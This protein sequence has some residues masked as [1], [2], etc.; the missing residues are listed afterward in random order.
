MGMQK[1]PLISRKA[2]EKMDNTASTHDYTKKILGKKRYFKQI[3]REEF[4][5]LF[6]DSPIELYDLT[7]VY[8]LE[9]FEYF[10][11]IRFTNTKERQVKRL[12]M[13][14]FLYLDSPLPYKKIN[15]TLELKKK[16]K[17]NIIGDDCYIKLPET[18]YKRYDI[19]IDEIEYRDGEIL[20]LSL[21]TVRAPKENSV[22]N[23]KE[24]DA[25]V[26]PY[27][28]S[29][30]YPAVI[31]PSFSD[32]LWI[33]TCGQ[34]NLNSDASCV[35]CER[36]RESLEE[37]VKKYESGEIERDRYSFVQRAKKA[38]HASARVQTEMTPEKEKLIE[39]QKIKVEKREK[40]KEKMIMQALPRIALYFA[41]GYLIYFLL[42]WL[43]VVR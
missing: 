19:F 6:E 22:K 37:M 32:S 26:T 35:R 27:H 28:K 42:Q 7:S 18:Y 9:S 25:S 36:T 20:P 23:I 14:V 12:E 1:H 5:F 33:C 15:Y 34:K 10:M 24:I 16:S 29:E 2:F 13:R 11:R 31:M 4:H 38:E 21:S 8:D 41:A 39:E 17:G 43:D 40:Y 3:S 30:K